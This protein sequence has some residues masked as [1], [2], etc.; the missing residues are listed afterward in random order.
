MQES[1]IIHIFITLIAIPVVFYFSQRILNKKD[2][3]EK[4]LTE[5]WHDSVKKMIDD[6]SKK[7]TAFCV[8]N[9]KDNEG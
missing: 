1:S 7:V 4:K 6:L 5:Q 9:K 2:E 3:A 8:D